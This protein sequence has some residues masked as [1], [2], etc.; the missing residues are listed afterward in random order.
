MLVQ[1]IRVA[2]NL[3]RRTKRRETLNGR[4]RGI[5]SYAPEF[6]K[7]NPAHSRLGD[8]GY[9]MRDIWI[10]MLLI[11]S[12]VSPQA[13]GRGSGFAN[14]SIPFHPRGIRAG[15]AGADGAC[16]GFPGQR[17]AGWE[18][19]GS[20]LRCGTAFE[21]ERAGQKVEYW[22]AGA[23]RTERPAWIFETSPRQMRFESSYYGRAAGSRPGDGF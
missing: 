6:R 15:P 20:T 23:A 12:F 17:Q 11:I 3:P 22:Q 19:P 18:S 10:L 5:Y 7:G 9:F 21:V 14:L 16:G 8:E 1:A 4:Q 2:G 13:E